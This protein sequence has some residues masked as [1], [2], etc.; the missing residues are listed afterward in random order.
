MKKFLIL[1]GICLVVWDQFFIPYDLDSIKNNIAEK[2]KEEII[3][4]KEFKTD[5]CTLWPDSF[6]DYQ[7]GELCVEHDISYWKGGTSEERL[8]SD[9]RFKNSA[10]AVMSYSGDIMYVS[11]RIFGGKYSPFHWRWGYGWSY[12]Y[13]QQLYL[14]WVGFR[15]D[16]LN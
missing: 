7:W 9:L 6:F 8:I 3:P 14:K 11:S 15:N 12:P 13:S 10:N 5:G 4:S 2:N 1:I 16:F